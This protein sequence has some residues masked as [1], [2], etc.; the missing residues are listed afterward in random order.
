[1]LCTC[2]MLYNRLRLDSFLYWCYLTHNFLFIYTYLLAY[3]VEQSPSW[4]ANQFSA[5]QEVPPPFVE[6]EGSLPHS[7]V[8]AT[9][10]YPEPAQSSLYPPHPTSW[11]SIFI[12]PFHLCLGLPSG[13]FSSCFPTKTLYMPLLSPIRAT[14]PAH[15]ILLNFITWTMLGEEYRSLS[16]SL[17]SFLHS[18]VTSFHLAHIFSSTPSSQTPLAYIPLSVLATKFYTHTKQQE[19][20]SSVYLNVSIFG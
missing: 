9:C 8:P 4:E 1:L 7:Q 18:P 2:N 15:L 19:N 17:C 10:P 5:S 11:S 16:S 13:L 20:Y 12:L 3:S 14:C 6:P